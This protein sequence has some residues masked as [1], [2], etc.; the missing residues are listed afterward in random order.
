MHYN[1]CTNFFSNRMVA[2][3]NSLPTI[4]VSAESTNTYKNRLDKFWANQD[5]KFD[6]N[7]DITGIGRRSINS[8]SYV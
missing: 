7:A 5:F 3:W 4:V 2:I 6:W 1:L 8:S